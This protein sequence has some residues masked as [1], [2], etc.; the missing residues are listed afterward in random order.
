MADKNRFLVVEL[1]LAVEDGEDDDATA[2]IDKDDTIQY[3]VVIIPE[4]VLD[5]EVPA[6]I[7]RRWANFLES[8]RS[9]KVVSPAT[10]VPQF[11]EQLCNLGWSAERVESFVRVYLQGN[12]DE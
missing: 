11:V 1:N 3:L 6:M 9:R 8:R 10:L 7:R 2:V 4:G 12:E 5:D